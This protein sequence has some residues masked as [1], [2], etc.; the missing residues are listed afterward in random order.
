MVPMFDVL[1]QKKYLVIPDVF[2]GA[3]VG[4]TENVILT[5]SKFV[6]G[7]VIDFTKLH[8]ELLFK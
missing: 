2:R 8:E 1:Q 5:F 4:W 7:Y 6:N 3:W